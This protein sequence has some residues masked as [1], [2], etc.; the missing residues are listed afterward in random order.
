MSQGLDS[1][2]SPI[3]NKGQNVASVGFVGACFIS[4]IESFVPDA[5]LQKNLILGVPFFS[6]CITE[7]VKWFW[8]VIGPENADKI[9]LR[10]LLNKKQ[11]LI[12][13]ELKKPNISEAHKKKLQKVLEAASLDRIN[14][15]DHKV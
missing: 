5:P 11:K 14:S 13:N 4:I 15:Y 2:K 3:I 9:K 7:A 10:L 6:I 12:E 1:G 8:G